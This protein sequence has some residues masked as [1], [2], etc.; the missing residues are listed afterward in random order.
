MRKVM[1]LLLACVLLCS[2]IV[3]ADDGILLTPKSARGTAQPLPEM[4]DRTGAC[5]LGLYQDTTLS[6]YYFN[7]DP[8][9]EFAMWLNPETDQ[10]P[11][12]ALVCSAPYYPYLIQGAWFELLAFDTIPETQVG[13]RY[14]VDV[15]VVCP[16]NNSPN[17]PTECSG[18]GEI[19]YNQRYCHDV[20]YDE[21]WDGS[22][23]NMVQ[24]D[25]PVCV[26]GPFFISIKLAYW[27]G[28]EGYAP[29]PLSMRYAL[30]ISM[31][32]CKTWAQWWGGS[33]L[34]FCWFNVSDDY[35]TPWGPWRFYVY[36]E[37]G[38]QCTPAV[39][40]PCTG[41][42]TGDNAEHPFVPM[43]SN[44]TFDVPLCDYCS[45]YSMIHNSGIANSNVTGA[46]PDVVFKLEYPPELMEYCFRIK[47][48][49]MCEVPTFFRLRSWMY[50][51]YGVL[52]AGNPTYPAAM[53]SQW[54]NFTPTA[55]VDGATTIPGLGCYP[56]APDVLYLVI[57]TRN[58]HCCCP[59]RV[60]YEG[61]Q[62][63]PVNLA[64]FDL[65][66][67]DGKVSIS[68]TTASESD[69]DRYELYRGDQRVHAVDAT[70]SATGTTYS[71]TDT[72]LENGQ[73]YGYSL[74]SVDI[75]GVTVTLAI[76]SATPTG[77]AVANEYALNQ[78]Y[79]N[80]FNPSTTISYSVKE[81][82]LVTLKVYTVDG[83]EV[84][85]LVNE[86]QN[87]SVYNVNFDGA[88]LASGVYLYT[89]KVN[90]FSATHKM[91]L[92]K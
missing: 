69:M 53:G 14:C 38:V 80:P 22:I 89:L 82:G 48:Q 1:G 76:A 62:P 66:P 60:I 78:N 70:N 54:Y 39:C 8:G 79:P 45:D 37:A 2:S 71:F 32:R 74:K 23:F 7:W 44:W 35:V 50:D 58:D 42:Y 12:T 25:E 83:R 36:G 3:L 24:F 13:F 84:A 55:W 21:W 85:T 72:G 9:D 73:T 41:P 88:N 30:P 40:P 52:Y 18:P 77:A 92:M 27:E 67:G 46:G 56:Y 91:V 51:S 57:D 86:V 4:T 16:A 6:R 11:D 33:P 59:V 49:P 81:A 26:N 15:R 20:T 47:L 10:L 17:Y 63:L 19:V 34:T 28:P 29:G 5:W 64:S 31:G 43:R 90:G 65:V 68:W 87:A 61:D 75:N